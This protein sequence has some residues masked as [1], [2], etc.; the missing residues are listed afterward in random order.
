METKRVKLIGTTPLLMHFDNLSF[1]AKLTA[2]R[3][4]PANK[5]KQVPGDDRSPAWTWLGYTYHQG[6]RV[7]VPSDNLMTMLREGGSKVTYKNKETFKKLSQSGLLVADSMWDLILPRGKKISWKE[8]EAFFSVDDIDKHIDGVVDLGFELSIKR[9]KVG[10]SKHVRV[11][12]MFPVGWSLEGD[13]MILDDAIKPQNFRDI[14]EQAGRRCG[15][16]DWRPSSP[17]SP[18]QYG[19]FTVEM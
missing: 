16:C 19:M 5:E 11:R 9:A 3:A 2:W 18:G 15:L 6:D 1:G 12:P 14:L 10:T 17:R 4:N 8:I 7:G 13:I